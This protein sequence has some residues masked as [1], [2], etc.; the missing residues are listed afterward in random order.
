M[1]RRSRC[2]RGHPWYADE[3]VGEGWWKRS[4]RSLSEV[5]LCVE[6]HC[7]L[8]IPH[9]PSAFPT[10][11]YSGSEVEDLQAMLWISMVA[12]TATRKTS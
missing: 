3:G 4:T 7:Q 6:L 2:Y 1:F 10:A 12:P 8:R 11:K 9:T 5:R